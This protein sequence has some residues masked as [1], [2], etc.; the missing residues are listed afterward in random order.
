MCVHVCMLSYWIVAVSWVS[1]DGCLNIN[2]DFGLHGLFFRDIYNF[3]VFVYKLLHWPLKCSTWVLARDTMVL[4]LCTYIYMHM[5]MYTW[6]TILCT[7]SLWI[8][9]LMKFASIRHIA[10][11]E[12]S[13]SFAVVCC[14]IDV[15]STDDPKTFKPLRQRYRLL[16]YRMQWCI[17]DLKEG[18]ARSIAR[19]ARTQKYLATPQNCWPRPSFTR[20]RR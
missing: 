1:A 10:Y 5:Y 16:W 6:V 2:C 13:H 11:Q 4:F 15:A 19:E 18:G 20:S 9:I 7:N 12:S 14:R 3:L 17:Q 8:V